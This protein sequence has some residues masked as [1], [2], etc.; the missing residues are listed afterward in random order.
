MVERIEM[1]VPGQ[2][3]VKFGNPDFIRNRTGGTEDIGT[4]TGNLAS[5]R[6]LKRL[7]VAI[8]LSGPIGRHGIDV[9]FQAADLHAILAEGQDQIGAMADEIRTLQGKD[10]HGFREKPVEA[11][12]D[13]HAAATKIINVRF[14]IP[15]LKPEFF[16]TEEVNFSIGSHVPLRRY[17]NG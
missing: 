9:I 15:R 2:G 16:L 3:N 1:L 11:D 6:E 13:P 4:G 8:V 5:A 12:H 17:H 7:A 10:P 14:L